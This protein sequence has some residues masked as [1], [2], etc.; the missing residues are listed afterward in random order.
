M[1]KLAFNMDKQSYQRKITQSSPVCID[2]AR[3]PTQF[4]EEKQL[5]FSTFL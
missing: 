1:E 2:V 5:V 3:F 4:P